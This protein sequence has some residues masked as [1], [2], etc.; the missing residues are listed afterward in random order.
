MGENLG[1]NIVSPEDLETK[2]LR[3]IAT[4]EGKLEEFE[5]RLAMSYEWRY[6]PAFFE[7]N[8]FQTMLTPFMD[9]PHF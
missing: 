2:E 4:A 5:K 3:R 8:I 7:C 9:T 1:D 6:F